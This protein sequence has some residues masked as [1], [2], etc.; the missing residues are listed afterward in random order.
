MAARP[1]Y[2]CLAQKLSSSLPLRTGDGAGDRHRP[3]RRRTDR[4]VTLGA[5]HARCLC[6][7]ANAEAADRRRGGLA[8]RGGARRVDLCAAWRRRREPRA[9]AGQRPRRPRPRQWPPRLQGVT[10]F[11]HLICFLESFDPS[12]SATVNCF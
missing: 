5:S 6:S 4:N 7:D 3:L 11:P 8:R 9:R 1:I 10:N 2:T 12:V